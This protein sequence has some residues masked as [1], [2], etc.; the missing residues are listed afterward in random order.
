[1]QQ[2]VTRHFRHRVP[3]EQ[4]CEL[5]SLVA[6]KY[7]DLSCRRRVRPGIAF[8][9][10]RGIASPLA[11]LAS[12]VL[13]NSR[14]MYFVL[15]VGRVNGYEPLEDS[16]FV[17]IAFCLL[18]CSHASWRPPLFLLRWGFGGRSM[19][20]NSACVMAS[21][22]QSTAISKVGRTLWKTDLDL[23]SSPDLPFSIYS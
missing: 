10:C 15:P 4:S 13:W 20:K 23:T 8:G 18:K 11:P 6:V 12:I 16:Y 1:M 19:K 2:C 21:G 5:R 7:S 3:H 22:T 17:R 9:I 14:M